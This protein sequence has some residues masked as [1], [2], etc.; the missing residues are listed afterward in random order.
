MFNVLQ[1]SNMLAI[2]AVLI[3]LCWQAI[4][5]SA[6]NQTLNFATMSVLGLSV[7]L[8]YSADRLFDVAKRSFDQLYSA[9][10]RFTKRH[11]KTLW[12]IWFGTLFINVSIAFSGLTAHQLLNGTVLLIVCLLYTGLNQ[13]LSSRFFPKELWVAILYVGG[14]IV[15]LLP[16]QSLWLPA[17]F[18]MLLCL[19]NCLIIGNKER[20]I[21]AAMK[22]RSLAYFLPKLPIVLYACCLPAI[23]FLEGA[24]LL[25]IGLSLL[26]LMFVHACQKRLSVE[27]FRL[28]ADAA[29]LIGPLFTLPLASH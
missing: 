21:D 7:W 16:D 22:V 28:F 14:V 1:W 2:D 17:G 27:S 11:A 26:A 10:H 13:K 6:S 8:T 25:S 12:K 20:Q 23:L 29:L 3:A 5:A 24:L 15:F 18:L 4:F 9:R 19:I